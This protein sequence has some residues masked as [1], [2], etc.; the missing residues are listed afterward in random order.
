LVHTEWVASVSTQSSEAQSPFLAHGAPKSPAPGIWEPVL[1]VASLPVPVALPVAFVPPTPP[2]PVPV[3]ALV[4]SPP[5]PPVV[6]VVVA[7]SPPPQPASVIRSP[8]VETAIFV[9]KEASAV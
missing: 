3:L 7:V 6:V 5:W 1:V 9:R 8:I 2:A 4:A